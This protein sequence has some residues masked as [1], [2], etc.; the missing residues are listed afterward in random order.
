MV[1]TGYAGYRGSKAPKS[2]GRVAGEVK[3]RAGEE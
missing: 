2:D 1:G 3:V